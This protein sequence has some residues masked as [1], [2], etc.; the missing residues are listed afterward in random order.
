[1]HLPSLRERKD[2]KAIRLAKRKKATLIV[3]KLDPYL[4]QSR[5]RTIVY[6]F[7]RICGD[8]QNLRPGA[9]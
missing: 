6:L 1:M 5:T 4:L 8:G 2:D 9:R 7:Q 3:A